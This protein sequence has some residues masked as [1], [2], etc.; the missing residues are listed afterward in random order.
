MEVAI[1]IPGLG[2][3][4]NGIQLQAMPFFGLPAEASRPLMGSIWDTAN[5][6]MKTPTLLQLAP[7]S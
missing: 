3:Q 5:L 1:Y 6:D 2:E 7:A 4:W